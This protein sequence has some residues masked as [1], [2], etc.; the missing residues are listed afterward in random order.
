MVDNKKLIKEFIKKVWNEKR[1]ELIPNFILPSY[2][3]HKLGKGG[4]LKGIGGV[5]FNVLDCHS[6]FKNFNIEIIKMIQDKNMISS[7]IVLHDGD[8]IMN[9]LIIHKI[10]NNRIAEAWSIGGNWL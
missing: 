6:R 3:A 2:V 8:K 7:W 1:V 5:K 4:N 10:V 9:E